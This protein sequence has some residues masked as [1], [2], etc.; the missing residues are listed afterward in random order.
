MTAIKKRTKRKPKQTLAEFRAWLSGVEELQL[1]EWSPTRE[2]WLLIRERIDKI[3]EPEP[4]I[5]HVNQGMPAPN[6]PVERP[7]VPGIIPP[8]PV[9]GGIPPD[10]IIES[11]NA[12][13]NIP[14]LP[15]E[16]PQPGAAQRSVTPNIDTTNGNYES[17]FI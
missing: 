16:M 6:R 11:G 12:P 5:I 7:M 15:S 2:Q 3:I 1:D 13:A 17:G 4:E 10:A 8:P 9:I 14:P